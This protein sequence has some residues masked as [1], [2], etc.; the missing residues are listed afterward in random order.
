VLSIGADYSAKDDHYNNLCTTEG[1]RV[2]DYEFLNAQLRWENSNGNV[3]ITLAGTNLTDEE[4]FNGGFDFGRA[5]GF[6]AAYMYPP[7]MWS[8]SARYSFD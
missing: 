2:A 8:L 1:I 4:V 3:L 6:A 5:L 7:R